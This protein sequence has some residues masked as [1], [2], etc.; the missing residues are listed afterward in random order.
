MIAV[1]LE[2]E[3]L[4]LGDHLRDKLASDVDGDA[5][6][7]DDEALDSDDENIK[8]DAALEDAEGIFPPF[9]VQMSIDPF[10]STYAHRTALFSSS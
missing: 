6:Q 10:T 5:A 4:D 2:A 8:L 7:S 9:A 1:A 3:D